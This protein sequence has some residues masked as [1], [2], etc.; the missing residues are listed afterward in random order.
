MAIDDAK[1]HHPVVPGDQLLIDIVAQLR[2][3]FGK[4]EAR[5]YV[6]EKLV[7]EVALKFAV[8]DAEEV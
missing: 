8:L 4:G 1:F 6:G 7:S 5:L 3:R 2:S